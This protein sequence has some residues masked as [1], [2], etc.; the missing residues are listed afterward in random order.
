[1]PF[2]VALLHHP[3]GIYLFL[4]AAIAASLYAAQRPAFVPTFAGL[5]ASSLA[6]LGFLAVPPS[7][8]ALLLL[9]TGVVLLHLE[10][11]L[12]TSGFAGTLGLGVTVWASMLLL[13]PSAMQPS[14]GP[15]RFAVAI[16]GTL[17][18]FGAV[19]HT[20]RLRTLPKN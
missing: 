20:M 11:L 13:A 6:C 5:A 3:A 17:V 18:V 2:A 4:V 7:Y 19:A 15:S 1:M 9:A 16:A 8:S 10:F 12:P 14:V